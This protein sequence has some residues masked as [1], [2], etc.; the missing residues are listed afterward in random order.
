MAG[1]EG[2]VTV[3]IEQIGASYSR[4]Y[5]WRKSTWVGNSIFSYRLPCRKL[6]T[7]R[8]FEAWQGATFGRRPKSRALSSELTLLVGT[9]W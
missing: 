4:V 1:R 8:K 5:G 3:L 7:G 6:G 9:R 2:D